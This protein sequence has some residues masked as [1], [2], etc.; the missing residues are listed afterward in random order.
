MSGSVLLVT[1]VDIVPEAEVEFNRWYNDVHLPEIL[2]CPGFKSCSRYE[3]VQ[4]E[5]RYLAIYE[6]ESEAAL[7]TPEMRKVRGWGDM[8]PHV[9]NFHERVY[10]RIYQAESAVGEDGRGE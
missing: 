7:H 8:F 1:S 5:P 3:A 2:V 6:L 9:R 10:R 4:G